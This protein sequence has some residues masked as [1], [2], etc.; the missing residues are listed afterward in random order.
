[1][2]GAGWE[3]ADS[4]SPSL[5]AQ[6]LR[7]PQLTINDNK[8]L[9]VMTLPCTHGI[10]YVFQDVGKQLQHGNAGTI[11]G[12]SVEMLIPRAHPEPFQG[13][14]WRCAFRHCPE[15]PK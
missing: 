11:W 2:G 8:Q 15:V 1:M 4:G 6:L 10:T 5:L 3:R 7:K 14:G 9:M 13:Q 12:S